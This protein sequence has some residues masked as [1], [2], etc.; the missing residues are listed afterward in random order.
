M[1]YPQMLLKASREALGRA[2]WRAY[3]LSPKIYELFTKYDAVVQ[4]ILNELSIGGTRV[5]EFWEML[6]KRGGELQ[7]AM[8]DY[9][10]TEGNM[11]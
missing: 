10:L 4:G 2:A 6:Y 3:S 8:R 11:E 5:P 9:L 7:K 1:N